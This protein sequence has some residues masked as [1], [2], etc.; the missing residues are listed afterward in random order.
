MT[1]LVLIQFSAEL[2]TKDYIITHVIL[3]YKE[4]SYYRHNAGSFQFYA[5][6]FRPDW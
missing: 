1:P 6:I 2:V 5:N 4:D 3:S